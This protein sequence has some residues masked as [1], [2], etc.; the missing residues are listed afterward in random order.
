MLD[1]DREPHVARRHAARQLLG[2]AQ[3]RVGRAGRMD[4]E[5]AHIAD[6]GDVIEELQR[7]DEIARRPR[8]PA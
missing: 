5:A 1:A 6:I 2:R 4:G 8:G 7:I 3:L